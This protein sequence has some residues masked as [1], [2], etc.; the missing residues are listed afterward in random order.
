MLQAGSELD[1]AEESLDAMAAAELR[2]HH[3]HRN[4]TLVPEIAGDVDGGHAAGADL[5]LHYISAAEGGCQAL[6]D[7]AHR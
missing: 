6:G 4:R 2:A 7:I 5:T 1:L 3:L